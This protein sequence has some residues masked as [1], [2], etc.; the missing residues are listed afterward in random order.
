MEAIGHQTPRLRGCF[1]RLAPATVVAVLL[2]GV[3]HCAVAES[4]PRPKRPERD[5]MSEKLDI[6]WEFFLT[7]APY[8]RGLNMGRYMVWYCIHCGRAEG[9]EPFPHD[10]GCL[11]QRAQNIARRDEETEDA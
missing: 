6:L 11:Y 8:R 4:S 2:H 1:G 10:S 9:R 5:T 3:L 7:S